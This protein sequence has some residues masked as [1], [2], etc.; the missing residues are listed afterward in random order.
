MGSGEDLRQAADYMQD[1]NPTYI[2]P[3]ILC[4]VAFIHVQPVY[5]RGVEKGCFQFG[6]STVILLLP[7][8]ASLI[9]PDIMGNSRE[10][11][12]TIV[13]MGEEIGVSTRSA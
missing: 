4:T 13:R 11:I 1:A 7:K 3:S 9:D 8:G 12:E 2:L 6:G 10:H 5:R